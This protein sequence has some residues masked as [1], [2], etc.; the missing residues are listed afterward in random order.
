[1]TTPVLTTKRLSLRAPGPSDQAAY[2]GFY[3]SPRR[4]AT[5]GLQTKT[6]AQA[7]FA[8]VLTHWRTKG[9][10]RFLVT[11]RDGGDIVGLIGPHRPDGFP[12]NEIAWHIWH[13]AHEGRGLAVEAAFAAR[14]F[15]YRDFGWST[16]VSYIADHNIRS[17]RLAMRLGAKADP[18]ARKLNEL[19]AHRVYRHP[20]AGELAP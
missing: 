3:T 1:M 11:L 7:G 13:D 19:V 17:Q 16:V 14:A 6:E 8:R 15:A 18:S 5:G 20:S 10:G 9:F 4:A 12:E 2:V